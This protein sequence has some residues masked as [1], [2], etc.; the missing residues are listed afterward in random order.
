MLKL[1]LNKI[2][3]LQGQKYIENNKNGRINNSINIGNKSNSSQE[4]IKLRQLK[5][6]RDNVTERQDVRLPAS[7]WMLITRR[8]FNLRRLFKD[9]FSK[10]CTSFQTRGGSY[11]EKSFLRSTLCSMPGAEGQLLVIFSEIIS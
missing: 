1:D 8:K 5:L 10:W 11:S 7:S 4:S 2:N 3:N 9:A 6:G